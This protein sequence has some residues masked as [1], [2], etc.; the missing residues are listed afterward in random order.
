MAMD[1]TKRR[2][3]KQAAEELLKDRYNDGRDIHDPAAAMKSVRAAAYGHHSTRGE[4]RSEVPVDDVLAALTQVEGARQQLERLELD[5]IRAVRARGTSWQRVADSLLLSSRQSAESRAM[6]LESAA[7]NNH[8]DHDV[9]GARLQRSRQRAADAW[10]ETHED[11]IRAVGERLY[12]AAGAWTEMDTNVLVA[13]HMHQLGATLAAGG[14]GP[15]LMQC[16]EHLKVTFAP[17]GEPRLAPTT[18]A[19]AGGKEVTVKQAA[20]AT[21]ARDAMLTLIDEL[22]NVRLAVVGARET[23]S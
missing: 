7:N 5:L 19:R 20:V 23:R 9:A 2:A 1:S 3:L 8:Q 21:E 18:G 22:S 13:S 17:Y 4:G 12:D 10:C 16:L 14:S 15:Q 6:R 11:R